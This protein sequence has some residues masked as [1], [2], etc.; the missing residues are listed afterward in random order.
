MP[1]H[2]MTHD[3]VIQCPVEKV[4]EKIVEKEV[5]TFVDRYVK[6][7]VLVDVEKVSLKTPKLNK[8][9]KTK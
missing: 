5:P 2:R 8:R 3:R 9:R 4:V 6:Q 7:D 1:Y